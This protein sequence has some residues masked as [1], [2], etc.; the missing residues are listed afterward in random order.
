[1]EADYSK[2]R[3][4]NDVY[5]FWLLRHKSLFL[6][7]SGR[8]IFERGGPGD[9]ENLRIRKSK[10]KI[11]YPDSVRFSSQKSGEEQKKK[12]VFALI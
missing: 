7:S 2:R 3:T 10:M 8:R 11:L 1:M 6:V 5:I 4:A 9:S 12:K